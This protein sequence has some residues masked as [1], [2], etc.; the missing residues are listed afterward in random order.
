MGFG[1][2]VRGFVEVQ[3]TM[4]SCDIMMMISAHLL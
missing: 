2:V 3:R 1:G 4:S